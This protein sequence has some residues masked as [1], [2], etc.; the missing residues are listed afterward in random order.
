MNE[1]W[2]DL[3][4]GFMYFKTDKTNLIDAV[5]DFR[6]KL[7]GIGCI[8]DNFGWYEIEL[9]DANGDPIESA[10]VGIPSDLYY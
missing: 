5:E 1:L 10:G 8:T 6:D 4:Y 2:M 7:D 9:R 3:G